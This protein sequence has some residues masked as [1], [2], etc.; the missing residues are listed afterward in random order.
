MDRYLMAALGAKRIIS[1][2][3]MKWLDKLQPCDCC[4]EPVETGHLV[5]L[6]D[7]TEVCEP[8]IEEQNKEG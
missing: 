4:N 5:P 8:C 6:E 2:K 1:Q 3:E 7:G